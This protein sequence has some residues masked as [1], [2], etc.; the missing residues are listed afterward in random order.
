LRSKGHDEKREFFRM[1]INAE[2]SYFI[3]D[4]EK[5]F[6]GYC[7]NLS[8]KG[9]QFETSRALKEGQIIEVALDAGDKRFKTVNAVLSITRIERTDRSSY[10]VAGRILKF[11]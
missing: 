8:H 4:E 10:K 5:K 3:P 1:R 6:N 9:M 11:K 7:I 2:F